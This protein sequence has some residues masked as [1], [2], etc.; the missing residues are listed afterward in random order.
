MKEPAKERGSAAPPGDEETL[1]GVRTKEAQPDEA[2]RPV[3]S[4]PAGKAIAGPEEQIEGCAPDTITDG[5]GNYFEPP[6]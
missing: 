2:S 1:E 3:P 4:T 5:D 6:D